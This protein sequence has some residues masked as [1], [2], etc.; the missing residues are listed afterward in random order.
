MSEEYLTLAE[1]KELLQKEQ[2]VRVLTME[3]NYALEHAI[4]YSKLDA[5]DSRKLANELAEIEQ[6]NEALACKLVDLMPK[7]PDEI[8]AVFLKER[9]MVEDSTVSQILD[10]V[11][12]Y[13]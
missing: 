2:E 10:K 6:V 12:R 7:H 4:K 8:Q 1:I 3:Q 13:I 5:K 9:T 11:K